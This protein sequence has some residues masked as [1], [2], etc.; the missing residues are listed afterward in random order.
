M[1]H[2]K[3]SY[4]PE[5]TKIK[6]IDS[7]KGSDGTDGCSGVFGYSLKKEQIIV[8]VTSKPEYYPCNGLRDS[9]PGFYVKTEAGTSYR[10]S[11]YLTHK[12]TKNGLLH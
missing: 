7:G 10:L 11:F 2:N 3:G 8:T 12:T 1:L 9:R 4:L 5:G 6:L